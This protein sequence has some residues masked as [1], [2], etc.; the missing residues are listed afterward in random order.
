MALRGRGSAGGL[1]GKAD[2]RLPI[3][4]TFED[5]VIQGV[6]D[7]GVGA[8]VGI[9]EVVGHRV[10]LRVLVKVKGNAGEGLIRWEGVVGVQV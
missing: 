7:L 9:R 4:R 10:V 2:G 6:P 3:L 8:S 1:Q 5:Q